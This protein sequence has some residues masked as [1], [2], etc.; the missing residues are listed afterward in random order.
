LTLSKKQVT[1][2]KVR[3]TKQVSERVETIDEPGLREEVEVE[4]VPVDRIVDSFPE[5]Q[6]DGDVTI[7]PV[8][9]EVYVV[10]KRFRVKEE[11]RV[12][13]IRKEEIHSQEVSLRSE[14][15]KVERVGIENSEGTDEENFRR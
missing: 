13:R 7:I 6:V 4:R 15:V 11:V 1:T 12:R 14:Q 8:V 10:K 2:G 3:I 5:V 9:E